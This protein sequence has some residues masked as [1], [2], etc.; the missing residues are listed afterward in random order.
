MWKLP[1]NLKRR[2]NTID[3]LD[4]PILKPRRAGP[5]TPHTANALYTLPYMYQQLKYMHQCF[6]SSPIQSIIE[7]ASNNQLSGVP[8][9]SKP[10]AM[11]K[12]L[13]PLPATLKGRMK[14]QCA[15]VRSTCAR[16][17]DRDQP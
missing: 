16:R 1:I 6:F 15:N 5:G 12:F 8:F 11:R 10:D 17:R 7:A 9:L 2:S 3:S 14:K 4:V 13:V